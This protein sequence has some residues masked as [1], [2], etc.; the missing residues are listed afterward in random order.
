MYN[1]Q[2]YPYDQTMYYN[3]QQ[4]GYEPDIEVREVELEDYRPDDAEDAPTSPPPSQ[5]P[6]LPSTFASPAQAGNMKSWMCNCLGRWGYL[7]LHRPGPFGRDLWFFPT[8][9]RRSGVSGYTWQAG[10]R[11]KVSYRYQQISNFMCFA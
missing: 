9:V 1:Q 3:P 8:E 5:A 4:Y 6:S 11:R 10:R 7:R 2:N